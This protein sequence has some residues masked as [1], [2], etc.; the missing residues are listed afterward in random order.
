MGNGVLLFY[1]YFLFITF[2]FIIFSRIDKI[3]HVY[4]IPFFKASNKKDSH[5]AHYPREPEPDYEQGH[6]RGRPHDAQNNTYP[7][8]RKENMAAAEEYD[9]LRRYHD[10][11]SIHKCIP[12]IIFS[13]NMQHFLKYLIIKLDL[14]KIHHQNTNGTFFIF[15][16]MSF[17][18]TILKIATN[19]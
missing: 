12:L 5:E 10:F 7:D 15:A 16:Q 8:H 3:I 18:K 4:F 17:L 2:I 13:I 1:F 9:R 14:F 6:E 11:D 19:V